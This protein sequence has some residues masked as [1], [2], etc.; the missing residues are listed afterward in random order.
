MVA[1]ADAPRRVP[2]ITAAIIAAA[3]VLYAVRDL[4][5]DDDARVAVATQRGDGA[6]TASPTPTVP[7]EL[8]TAAPGTGPFGLRVAYCAS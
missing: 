5:A 3:A 4:R 6:G 7:P 1:P 2:M 8:T